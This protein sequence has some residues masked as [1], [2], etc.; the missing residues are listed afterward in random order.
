MTR[1]LLIQ[2]QQGCCRCLS[3]LA[4]AGPA[5]PCVALAAGAGP[6]WRSI[7]LRLLQLEVLGPVASEEQIPADES[8]HTEAIIEDAIRVVEQHRNDTR[9]LRDAHAKAHGCVKAEVRVRSDPCAA[10]ATRRAARAG[11]L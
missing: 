5:G 8:A 2:L 9:V 11:H 4:L 10:M 7:G 1:P 3:R 6:D